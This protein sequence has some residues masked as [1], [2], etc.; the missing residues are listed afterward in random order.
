VTRRRTIVLAGVAALVVL[1][2]WAVWPPSEKPF[3][4]FVAERRAAGLPTTYAELIGPAPPASE[5]G[6][7]DLASAWR[8]LVDGFGPESDWKGSPFDATTT[9]DGCFPDGLTADALAALA[10]TAE[11]L[12]PGIDPIVRA[13]DKPR[14]WFAVKYDIRGW[15]TSD[16]IELILEAL[17]ALEMAAAG[18]PDPARRVAACRALLLVADRTEPTFFVRE[19]VACSASSAAVAAIRHGVET[20]AVDPA[21][22]RAACDSLLR[23]STV[24]RLRR[25]SRGEAV[26]LMDNYAAFLDGR[27]VSQEAPLTFGRRMEI[28]FENAKARLRGDAV[29]VGWGKGFAREI[30]A[31]CRAW[32]SFAS[33]SDIRTLRT[34]ES[35][36]AAIPTEF[37]ALVG[38]HKTIARLAGAS[39]EAEAARALARVALAVA[40]FHATH[41]DFPASLDGLKAS[42]PEG[43]PLDPF[44]DAPFV[45]ET[46]ATGVRIASAGRVAGDPAPDEKRLRE[47]CLV[48]ELKR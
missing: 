10:A 35:V 47:R 5:N 42:F 29:S 21:K 9:L 24:E 45:Y 30:V 13:V 1:F 16:E 43:V 11:R 19:M 40:E 39:L 48:W 14:L 20:G 26:C 23:A 22:A 8:S 38:L 27:A 12:R 2:A 25:A 31:V 7:A 41:G 28:E 34:P 4:D 17:K 46:T 44:T 36:A 15:R 18:D 32:E 33:T 3:L 6:A 37:D